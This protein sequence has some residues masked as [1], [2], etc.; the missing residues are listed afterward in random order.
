MGEWKNKEK[1]LAAGKRYYRE[2]KD[3]IAEKSKEYYQKIRSADPMIYNL[4]GVKSRCKRLGIP[5]NLTLDDLI[6]PEFCPYLKIPLKWDNGLKFDTPSIDRIVPEKGYIKGNVQV[7]SQ[8][9]NL[10][11]NDASL[12]QLRT[13]AQ[14][15]LEIHGDK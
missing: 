8:R 15:V 14:S 12:E 13:F 3:R 1:R 5:F 6:V 9:A 10:M 11:K 7:I 2:N 4:R